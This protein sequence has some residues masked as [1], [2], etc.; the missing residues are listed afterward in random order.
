MDTPREETSL[1]EA[2]NADT[3]SPSGDEARE[4]AL[5]ELEHVSN[6]LREAK[7]VLA[8]D[9]EQMT[10]RQRSAHSKFVK[11]I[12]LQKQSLLDTIEMS[13]AG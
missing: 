1:G 11:E 5:E 13:R 7:K 2:P 3:S 4:L 9:W 6:R 10:P 12:E 8:R